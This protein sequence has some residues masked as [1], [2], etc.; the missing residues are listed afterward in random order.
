MKV[1]WYKIPAEQAV[2]QGQ[3]PVGKG[4][5][6]ETGTMQSAGYPYTSFVIQLANGC[7][8][9]KRA[10]DVQVMPHP[11]AEKPVI[12]TKPKKSV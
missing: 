12:P 11:I 2:A 10:T 8:I 4:E 7:L 3:K 1:Q 5:V 9:E 6:I